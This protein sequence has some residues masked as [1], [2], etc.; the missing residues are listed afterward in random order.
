MTPGRE[1][2]AM[3]AEKPKRIDF[4]GDKFYWNRWTGYYQSPYTNKK[5]HRVAW[6]LASGPIPD[7]FDIHHIDHDKR[8]NDL[9]NLEIISH[10]EHSAMHNR[11]CRRLPIRPKTFCTAEG[12]SRQ[13]KAR[14]LCTMHYQRARAEERGHWL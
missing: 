6:E 3:V 1:L 12:C 11:E 14:N 13:A 5:L 2:D 7:G 4:G 9:S 8:N 10:G